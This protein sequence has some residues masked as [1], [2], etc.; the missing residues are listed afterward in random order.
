MELIDIILLCIVALAL[1]L[2]VR[3]RVRAKKNGTGCC[4]GS[5]A[6]CS[7]CRAEKQK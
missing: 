2:A 4:S 6:G 1:F 3:S 7:A 5:C